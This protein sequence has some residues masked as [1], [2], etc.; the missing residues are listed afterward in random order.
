MQRKLLWPSVIAVIWAGSATGKECKEINFPSQIQVDGSTLTLNGLGMRQA[1][2]FKV[3]VYVAALYLAKT[4]SDANAILGAVAPYELILHFV[5][6]VSADDIEKSWREG[7]ARNA[8]AQLPAFNERIAK[9]TAWMMDIKTG[10][11]LQFF[12][13]PGVGVEVNV[14]GTVKGTVSG[15]D[16]GKAF[17][18]IWLGVPPN[19]EIKVGML[20]GPC[21]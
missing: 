8:G 11:R 16:F 14:N 15:D 5:R 18:S 10:Q 9:L 12:F 7:F 3:D 13:K 1:T 4:S 2:V 21:G 17:L 19:P 20:G 6:N